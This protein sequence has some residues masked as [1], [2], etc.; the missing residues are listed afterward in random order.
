MTPASRSHLPE[1][2]GIVEEPLRMEGRRAPL[3]AENPPPVDQEAESP[4][5]PS[6]DHGEGG[7]EQKMEKWID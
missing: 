3:L 6:A 2:E 1:E 5:Q 7:N 4:D